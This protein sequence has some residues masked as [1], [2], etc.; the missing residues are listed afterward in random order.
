MQVK[1]DQSEG[2]ITVTPGQGDPTTYA[3]KDGTVT[4][5]ADDVTAFLAVVDGSSVSK[6]D[7]AKLPA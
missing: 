6:T 7:A 1:V 2:S 4:V 5:A 3:V